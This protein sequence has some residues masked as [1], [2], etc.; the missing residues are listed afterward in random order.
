MREKALGKLQPQP[1]S[2]QFTPSLWRDAVT[3]SAKH[4]EGQLNETLERKKYKK[5]EVSA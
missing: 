1:L 4:V 3:Q 2:S 5:M